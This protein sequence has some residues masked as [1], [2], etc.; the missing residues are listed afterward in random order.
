MLKQILV[1]Q[2][3]HAIPQYRRFEVEAGKDGAR[4]IEAEHM[5][6]ALAAAPEIEAGRL[7]IE[8]GLDHD[9]L[10]AALRDEHRESLAFAGFQAPAERR[11]EATELDRH[12]S[13]GTSAKAAL[14][15]AV[16]AS[17]RERQRRGRLASIDVLIG[18]LQAELGT[19]PRAL[20]IAGV[21][22]GALIAL[23]RR[24]KGVTGPPC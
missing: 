6:L 2:A 13:M 8:S 9:R 16:H 3:R 24:A 7:L 15:R 12:I 18:I 10:T 11:F 21:D 22:R 4:F 14:G 20:A 17:H 19:V 23:A 5:L 1:K